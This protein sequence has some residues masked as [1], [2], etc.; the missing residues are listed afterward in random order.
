M[1]Y[2]VRHGQTDWNLERR[3][4]GHLDMPL[5]ETGRKEAKICGEQLLSNQIDNIISSDLSRAKE[6]ALIINDFLRVPITFDSRLRE[7]NAGNLQGLLSENIT[8]E[9][10]Y[11]FNHEPHKL[12][13]ESL[14][15]VYKRVKSFFEEID[16]TKNTLLVTHGGIIRMAMYLLQNPNS[17]NLS[18]YEEKFLKFKIKNTDVFQW[19][20]QQIAK[21]IPDLDIITL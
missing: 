7:I 4:Q 14:Q 13:A 21:L 5:N 6:T 11:I 10:W 1:I 17:F 9:T 15:D 18:E 2:L 16:T 19:N 3:L 12:N 8:E 20:K